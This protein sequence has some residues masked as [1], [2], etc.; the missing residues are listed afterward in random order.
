M[1]K[2]KIKILKKTRNNI[3]TKLYVEND[4]PIP[5]TSLSRTNG[6]MGVSDM[7]PLIE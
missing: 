2:S 4:D 3:S 1:S 5:V 7:Q 6:L